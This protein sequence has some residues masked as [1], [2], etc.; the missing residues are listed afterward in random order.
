MTPFQA[1]NLPCTALFAGAL[2][3][4]CAGVTPPPL[5]T[6]HLIAPAPPVAA[7][8]QNLPPLINL[9]LTPPAPQTSAPLETFAVVVNNVKVQDLLFALARDARLNIDIHPGLTGRVTM[10]AHEQT[11]PQILTRI[12]HQTDLRFERDGPNLAVMPDQPVLRNYKLDYVNIAREMTSTMA[13]TT[14]VATN[15]PGATGAPSGGTG[16]N[17]LTRIE[18]RASN[19]FWT[20]LI[21]NIRDILR[22][23]DKLLPEG[24]SEEVEE[25]SGAISTTGTGQPDTPATQGKRSRPAST[26]ALIASS[27]QPDELQN[28][29]TRITRRTTYREAASV[30]ANTGAGILTVR[31][32][33]RQH[34]KI[35][36]FIDQVMNSA[37]KQVLIEA[38]VVEVELD[39]RYRQGIDWSRMRADGTGV[40]VSQVAPLPAT[41][42]NLFKLGYA[43]GPDATLANV[44]GAIQLL[45]GFGQVKVLSSPKISVLNNQSA[46][47]KVVDN[48]VYFTITANTSTN[49]STTVTTFSTTLNSVPV[50]FVMNVTP[51]V[52]DTDQVVLNVRPSI[53]RKVREVQD[54]NPELARANVVSKV[55][56]IRTREMESMIRVENGSVVV[57]GGL[58]EDEQTRQT[59]TLPG[60]TPEAGAG[61][62]LSN[63]DEYARKTEL[64]IFI[65]PVVIRDA[66]MNGDYAALRDKLPDQDFFRTRQGAWQ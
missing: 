46:V 64:V 34:E 5:G 3:S 56:V 20:T 17:T 37:R 60:L 27:A 50:G 9:P 61:Q 51:Q 53:S 13:V 45:E 22:E 40:A 26:E 8:E 42:P 14:Q 6:A 55:P 24:S 33:G 65:R 16:N 19:Q 54:P 2:L 47:L 1:G 18:N 32:T 28:R 41:I 30:I 36:A 57:M 48:E 10:S 35:Q 52:S 66:S 12:S 25:I 58:M 38:T 23:T 59:D 21:Q 49:Q 63:R 62:V 31:A 15:A 11:L 44:R 7:L 39:H 43:T 4:G 29:G